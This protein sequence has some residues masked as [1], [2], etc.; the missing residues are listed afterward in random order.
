MT[1]L[2]PAM[3]GSGAG[4]QFCGS[5]PRQARLSL[6]APGFPSSQRL[7]FPAYCF[8]LLAVHMI[9]FSFFVKN[10]MKSVTFADNEDVLAS[11]A[12][13]V[14]S[15]KRAEAHAAGTM[16]NKAACLALTCPALCLPVAVSCPQ[17]AALKRGRV[18]CSHLH[19]HVRLQLHVC[20]LLP[21][22]V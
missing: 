19:G 7:A 6:P 9:D 4:S 15:K 1:V 20:L 13:W 22:G 2:W 8:F 12:S 21:G 11:I 18:A 3:A 17:L 16:K 14:Y 5:P 10:Q